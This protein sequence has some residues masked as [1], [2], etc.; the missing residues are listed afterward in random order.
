MHC[1]IQQMVTVGIFM[2]LSTAKIHNAVFAIAKA[3]L[4]VIS[5]AEDS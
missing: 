5:I 4:L 1:V 3:A 2:I